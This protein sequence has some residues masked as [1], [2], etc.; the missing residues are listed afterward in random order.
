MG[1]ITFIDLSNNNLG[2]ELKAIE[3]QLS[4]A[5]NLKHLNLS[6]TELGPEGSK[7][8]SDAILMNNQMK[9][10]ELLISRSR[11]GD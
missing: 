11:L 3:K 9:L 1:N 8:V 7:I 6:N 2:P 5:N 4:Q 10:T